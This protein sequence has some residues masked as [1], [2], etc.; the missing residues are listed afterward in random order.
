M[1]VG[2]IFQELAKAQPLVAYGSNATH[3]PIVV[4][5]AEPTLTH[6]K[7]PKRITRIPQR[8]EGRA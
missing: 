3:E 6:R 7:L 5:L 1:I 2:K 8:I 4:P